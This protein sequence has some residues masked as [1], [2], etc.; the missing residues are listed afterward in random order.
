M[1]AHD[2]TAEV[3]FWAKVNI[4]GSTQPHM[5][6]ACWEWTAGLN[7]GYGQ[8]HFEGMRS[9]AAHRVSWILSRGQIPPG[10][11]VC[12]RCDNRKCVRPEHLFLG[13]PRENNVDATSK[14]R[15]RWKGLCKRGHDMSAYGI[16]ANKGKSRRC[17]KCKRDR[18]AQE[19]P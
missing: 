15:G 18:L 11:F 8:F 12:H 2:A 10:M 13:T 19:A 7:D 3:R 5:E 14:G 1:T 17:G 9:A 16:P 6:S 4:H